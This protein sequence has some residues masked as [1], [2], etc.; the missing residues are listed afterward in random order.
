MKATRPPVIVL[1][2]S[3]RKPVELPSEGRHQHPLSGYKG[4]D[5]RLSGR[6]LVDH[7]V[8]R[9]RA[10]KGFSSVF[11][12]GPERVFGGLVD[13]EALIDTDGTFGQN[14]TAALETVSRSFPD[15]PVAFTT[16]DILP[17]ISALERLMADYQRCFPCDMWV[18][19]V[20]APRDPRQLGA[21]EWKPEYRIVPEPGQPGLATLPGH[22]IVVDPQAL[23]LGFIVDLFQI[24]YT[25]RNRPITRRRN[26]M[27]RQ[28]VLKLL[29]QDIL[30]VLGMR[31]PTLTWTVVSAGVSAAGKLN[32]G[33]ITRASL[34]NALRRMFVKQRHRKR[35]PH[36]RVVVSITDEISLALDMDTE[37]EARALADRLSQE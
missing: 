5:I 14:I 27:L 16:C 8:E 23:R 24:A 1:G 29:Y 17:E 26:T 2:G 4:V 12:A 36:R 34:E 33:T 28:L 25:T 9:L 6:S 32:R 21:S 35:Y 30:H 7:L 20:Q 15:S 10:C 31:L 18:T 11:V 37:E 13:S 22:L 3:D 19:L